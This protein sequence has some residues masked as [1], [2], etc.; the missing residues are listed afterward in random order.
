[1]LSYAGARDLLVEHLRADAI[2]HEAGLYDRVG[3]RFDSVERQFP[4]GTAPEL[5]KLHIALTFWDGWIDARNNGWPLGPIAM[6]DWPGLAR[7]VAS[8][9][10]ADR[11]I[12]DPMVLARFDI[13][14]HPHLNDRVQTLALRL[15]SR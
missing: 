14:A 12:S 11:E 10:E 3:R 13:V 15:R 1:M 7:L 8:D 2:V 5:G 9:L 4:I 6:A